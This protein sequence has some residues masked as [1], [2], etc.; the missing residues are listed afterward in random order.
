MASVRYPHMS[1]AVVLAQ[2]TTLWG[3][4]VMLLSGQTPPFTF[5]VMRPGCSD[6]FRINQTSLPVVGTWGLVA[7]VNGDERTGFWM[8][9]VDANYITAVQ[10]IQDPYLEF[11]SHYSGYVSYLDQNSIS[12]EQ[13][14]DGTYILC[15]NSTTPPA[16][17]RTIVNQDQ[18]L[19]TVS[20]N[21]SDRITNI[22]SPRYFI[23]NHASGTDTEI[24]PSGAVSVQIASGG[25]LTAICGGSTA[26][27]DSSGNTTFTGASGASFE[28]LFNGATLKIDGSGIV[29]ISTPQPV[30][31]GGSVINLQSPVVLGN[32]SGGSASSPGPIAMSAPGMS[33]TASGGTGLALVNANLVSLFNNHVHGNGNGGANTTAPTTAMGSS[34]LTSILKAE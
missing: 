7:F 32:S 8:G 6:S 19:S 18:S 26:E 33:I 24:A 22:P 20:L 28:A 14:A 25:T 13:F 31:V 4:K 10:N 12:F 11:E 9:S 30:N 5:Q 29:T 27:I 3:V 16:L 15:S 17:T 23:L 2:D 1:L 34:D 21:L